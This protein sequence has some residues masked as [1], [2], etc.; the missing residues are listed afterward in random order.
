MQ[1]SEIGEIEQLIAQLLEH[2]NWQEHKNFLHNLQAILAGERNP[3]LADDE[4]L[5]YQHAAELKLLLER[6]AEKT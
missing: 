6:V 3:A 1:Q 4:S 2:D 5:Y